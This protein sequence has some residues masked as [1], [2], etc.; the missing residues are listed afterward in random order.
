MSNVILV[1]FLTVV[2]V[3]ASCTNEN[4]DPEAGEAGAGSGAVVAP[5]SIN[6]GGTILPLG[7]MCRGTWLTIAGC[8][9]D[10]VVSSAVA[11]ELICSMQANEST[12]AQNPGAVDA[13]CS[14]L[15]SMAEC[16]ATAGAGGE[17]NAGANAGI[18]GGHDG[19]GNEGAGASGGAGRAGVAESG[20]GGAVAAGTGSGGSKPP[21]VRPPVDTTIGA[22]EC[23]DVCGPCDESFRAVGTSVC[24]ES[25][26]CFCDGS[27]TWYSTVDCVDHRMRCAHRDEATETL[28]YC[29]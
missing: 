5:E 17:S 2:L 18:G 4:Y 7:P 25:R 21:R 14:L 8:C 3:S 12:C 26:L 27:G 6:C 9:F 19:A 11:G 13:R 10:V 28:A 20:Q 23:E 16:Q 24:C 22:G 15:R 29:H 1:P